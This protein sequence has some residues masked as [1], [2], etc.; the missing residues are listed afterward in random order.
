MQLFPEFIKEIPS[1][2]FKSKLKG[3]KKEAALAHVYFVAMVSQS[4]IQFAMKGDLS[5]KP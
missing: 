5:A 3:R 2:I 1:S 4:F